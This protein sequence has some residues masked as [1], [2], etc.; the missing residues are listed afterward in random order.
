MDVRPPVEMAMANQRG[1]KDSRAE[2]RREVAW[3]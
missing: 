1:E 3:R 2:P